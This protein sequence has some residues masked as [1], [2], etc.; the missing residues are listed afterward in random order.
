MNKLPDK[1]YIE[2]LINLKIR[3]RQA[4]L[5]AALTV[6]VHLL[7]IYWEIGKTILEQQ[8]NEGWGAKIIDRLSAD[9]QKEFPDMKGFS[10]RN[11]KYMKAFSEAYP[12][13]DTI[14]QPSAAQLKSTQKQLPSKVQGK[15]AQNKSLSETSFVQ[16]PLAQLSWY[17]H[18]T[19][20][21]KVKD[22]KE[23]SFYINKT[24]ENGWSRDVMV[25]QIESKL[26]KRQGRISSNFKD[27]LI[28]PQSE[29]V[30][31]IFKDPY[32]FDFIYLGEEAKERDIEDALTGQITKFLLELGQW[33]AFVGR[34]YKVTLGDKE[35][36]F[37]LLFYHTRLRR[38]I[39]IDLKIDDFK[40]EYKGKMEFYLNL[41]D[42]QLKQKDDENSIGLILCKTKDGLVAEYA[43]RDSK[44]PIGIA[45]Y[46]INE[47]LPKNI[48]KELPTIKELE[49]EIEKEY[50]ELK[51]PS[52]KRLD[53]LK[54]KLLKIKSSEIKA[55]TINTTAA[56]LI[57]KLKQFPSDTRI[58]VAGYEDG[59]NDINE[60][61]SINIKLNANKQWHEGTHAESK[62]A[63]AIKAVALLG[64][65]VNA[66]D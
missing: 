31:Q 59:F 46:K 60:L 14:V 19:L 39:V 17:H 50:E 58:V 26:F 30:Q 65:N 52:Q 53:A 3:I 41:A 6:N 38:Y 21:D 37:D 45:E 63:H 24:I 15:L 4:Q 28:P 47:K 7:S 51:S 18:I 34:Q 25:H 2:V 61:R 10:I 54:E 66:K 62:D 16:V 5:K 29:L 1:Q 36:F 33:F 49:T 44:K 9:L 20:L 8:S 43:L 40:P 35:Y 32:K 57:E 64:K 55:R 22:K 11:L 56:E 13:F 23:R 27:I 12:D 48:Q 42:E